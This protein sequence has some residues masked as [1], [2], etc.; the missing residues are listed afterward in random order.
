[1]R[2]E[3]KLKV[4]AGRTR[5]CEDRWKTRENRIIEIIID[6]AAQRK[7]RLGARDERTDTG[8]IRSES[9]LGLPDPR[10][11]EETKSEKRRG[12]KAKATGAGGGS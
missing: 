1:M 9:K 3:Q 4:L 6:P 8:M 5:R 11:E 12:D 2:S 7:H 10:E